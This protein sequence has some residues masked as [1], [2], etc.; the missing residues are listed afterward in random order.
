MTVLLVNQRERTRFFRFLVVGTF[1]AVVDFGI[2]NVLH[3]LFGMP[4]VWAGSISFICAILSNFFWN[5]YWTYPDSRSKPL[6]R[7]LLQF[8]LI[9]TIGL[10]IRIPILKFL[11]PV[12]SKL[13][14]LLPQKL[15]I[16]PADM[17]G[18]N[19]T[20]A[21]AVVIVLFWNFFANRYWTYSDVES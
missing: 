18:E 13:C 21:I 6:F 17:M 14:S 2:E 19:L 20:L 9:N 8:A 5:R 16:L 3:R 1:G 12:I 10:F 7:Q 11:E 4:Y 15:L